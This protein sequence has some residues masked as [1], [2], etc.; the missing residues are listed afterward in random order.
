M[1][2]AVDNIAAIA[3]AMRRLLD[4]K[5]VRY[6]LGRSIARMEAALSTPEMFGRVA[7]AQTMR[8]YQSRSDG[9]TRLGVEPAC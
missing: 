1:A 5:S 8:R 4:D 9:H 2:E 3:A 7:I 6:R